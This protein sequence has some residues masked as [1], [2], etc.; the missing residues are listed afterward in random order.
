MNA[1]L[2]WA[3][4]CSAV[5]AKAL[6]VFWLLPYFQAHSPEDYAAGR[7]ADGYDYIAWNLVQGNGYRVSPDTSL[8]M[9]RTPGFVLL[10]A[11]IFVVFGKSL[12]A[13][14]VVNLLLSSLTAVLTHVWA[15][16]AGLS[17]TAATIAA[18]VFFLHPGVVVADSRAGVESMLTLCLV[19]TLLFAVIAMERPKWSS[20]AIAGAVNGLAL[21]VKSSVAPVLPAFFLYR[22]WTT[23]VAF[24][25][26]KSLAGIAIFGV[27]TALVITPWVVRNFCLSGEFIPT[28]TVSGLAAFQGAYVIKH[29]DSKVEY[30]ELL[31]HAADEQITIA[32]SM[33]L[34]TKGWFFPQFFKVEDEVSFYR[35]LGRRAAVDYRREP[36][37]IV[38]AIVHN[39]W[40]FWM[41]GRTR[42]ATMLNAILTLPLLTLSGIGLTIGIKR[43]LEVSQFA[44][45]IVVFMIPHLFILAMA[46]YYIPLVPFVA[47]LAAIPLAKWF[48]GCPLR[49]S[50][51]REFARSSMRS[52]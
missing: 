8:T 13:V 1:R 50:V 12:V 46:R 25:R 21:L 35:E 5:A 15:R 42:R 49:R 34:K 33:G 38:H 24:V 51:S 4:V 30:V 27:S 44:L 39:A 37:L 45:I 32:N 20:F 11:L 22:I 18:L 2:P 41:T 6:L 28:M 10:L 7:F 48:E 19:A 17:K 29:L 16:K 14:Q 36:K 52:S 3:I 40:A 47:I 43:G 9:L 23:T 26:R 31:N